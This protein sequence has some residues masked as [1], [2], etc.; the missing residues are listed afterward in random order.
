MVIFNG[1]Q[2]SGHA[3]NPNFF[4]NEPDNTSSLRGAVKTPWSVGVNWLG[5]AFGYQFIS[6]SREFGL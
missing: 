2:K 6:F 4:L 1:P 5:Q 3:C